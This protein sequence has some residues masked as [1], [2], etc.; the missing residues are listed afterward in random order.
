MIM[1]KQTGTFQIKVVQSR[2]R[3]IMCISKRGIQFESLIFYKYNF[4]KLF[5]SL[6]KYKKKLPCKIF[7]FSH[8][9]SRYFLIHF[10]YTIQNDVIRNISR[11]SLVGIIK[12]TLLS[13]HYCQTG[14]N[15]ENL[16]FKDFNWKLQLFFIKL[17]QLS[18][19]YSFYLAYKTSAYCRQ[20][21]AA[22]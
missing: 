15:I 19:P 6:Q 22:Y 17:Q 13:F 18:Q 5:I 12:K 4:F 16:A 21:F 9:F 14:K 1:I 10:S 11:G 7:H 20:Y 3:N 2:Y 8:V